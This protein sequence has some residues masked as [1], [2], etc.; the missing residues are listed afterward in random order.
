MIGVIL[1][2]GVHLTCDFPRI[3]CL[4]RPV[5][6]RAYNCRRFSIPPAVLRRHPRDDGGRDGDSDGGADGCSVPAGDL[7]FEEELRLA[8]A[9][10]QTVC[11]VQRI[12]VLAPP[13][14]R[15]LHAA[16]CPLHV[17]LSNLRLYGENGIAIE[18]KTYEVV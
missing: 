3:A 1:H 15:H 16:H 7:A 18:L 6:L 12:L 2:G 11:G 10:H 8:A 9:A 4:R 14:H 17:P 5:G 13:L